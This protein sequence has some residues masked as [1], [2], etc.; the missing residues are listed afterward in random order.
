VKEFIV[1][2]CITPVEYYLIQFPGINT[3]RSMVK[4][5]CPFHDD[6]SPSLSVNLEDGWYKCHACGE[7]GGGIVKFHMTRFNL[8]HKQT[9]KELELL[10][11]K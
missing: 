11:V 6:T 2:F 9:I 10:N 1:S 7:G 4:V 5:L 3:N 8:S